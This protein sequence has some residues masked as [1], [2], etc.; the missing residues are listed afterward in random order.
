LRVNSCLVPGPTS[1]K[2][3]GAKK[4][5]IQEPSPDQ[6]PSHEPDASSTSASI[7]PSLPLEATP[8][9]SSLDGYADCLS[10]LLQPEATGP[11]R[12]FTQNVATS[13]AW[14]ALLPKLVYPLMEQERARRGRDV[15]PLEPLITP[16]CSCL[17]REAVVLVV[18]FTCMYHRLCFII[19]VSTSP[20][21]AITP[22]TIQY[23][24]CTHPAIVLI[25]QGAF[26]STPV[27]P[28]KWAFNLQYLAFI[29]EQFLAGVPNYS[30]WC[31]GAVAFLTKD[32]CPQV[33]SA[34]SNRTHHT[35]ICITHACSSQLS[36]DLYPPVYSIIS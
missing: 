12:T 2:P 16:Q 7:P 17:Q 5:K 36:L 34:V 19:M 10:E 15:G 23:C 27:K 28:P 31:N 26:T 1:S 33:P 29:R 14:E 13:G 6:R 11:S 20:V 9:A 32:G 22:L 3:P 30:A 8:F 4:R 35:A 21:L 18:S 24:Q 25:H